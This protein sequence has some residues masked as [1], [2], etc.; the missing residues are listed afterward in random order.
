MTIH[1][2]SRRVNH[3]RL[4]SNSPYDRCAGEMPPVTARSGGNCEVSGQ[5]G[6]VVKLEKRFC[7]VPILCNVKKKCVKACFGD[8]MMTAF[9]D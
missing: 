9:P 8:A 4:L 5:G 7:R 1:R 2:L 3:G 6:V